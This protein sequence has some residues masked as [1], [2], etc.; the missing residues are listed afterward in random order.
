[1][2][3]HFK[4]I[5][6]LCLI[7]IL[8][9]ACLD[10]TN[11]SDNHQAS[12]YVAINM[13]N[14]CYALH[15]YYNLEGSQSKTIEIPIK[16]AIEG[17]KN[18]ANIS[19]KQMYKNEWCLELDKNSEHTSC[20]FLGK[21][22]DWNLIYHS[23]LGKGSGNFTQ[24]IKCKKERGRLLVVI[25]LGPGDRGHGGIYDIPIFDGK[26]SVYFYKSFSL[27]DFLFRSGV[28]EKDIVISSPA[29]SFWN[30]T[31]CVYSLKTDKTEII[32]IDINNKNLDPKLKRI[33]SF[34]NVSDNQQIHIS[35]QN[36]PAFLEKFKKSYLEF[37]KA[38]GIK[39]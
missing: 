23:W 26:N 20:F 27:E 22:K 1:M 6:I 33:F 18:R 19:L 9:S 28:A 31:K 36:I 16:Q 13:E 3:K 5:C 14:I 4:N 24:I 35:K 2:L 15:E 37:I 7:A 34:I 29:I 21:W 12:N 8:I 30:T 10:K 38:K 32:S 11:K 25:L 39:N 17:I